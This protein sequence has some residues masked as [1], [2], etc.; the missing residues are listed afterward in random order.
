LKFFENP[1]QHPE[2]RLI[3]T[4]CLA[5]FNESMKEK[6]VLTQFFNIKMINHLKDCSL[7]PA[8]SSTSCQ[9]LKLAIDNIKVLSAERIFNDF[10]VEQ[11]KLEW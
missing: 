3:V 4:S 1:E 10:T 11:F 2:S 6:S 8:M 7:V 9:L 5:I